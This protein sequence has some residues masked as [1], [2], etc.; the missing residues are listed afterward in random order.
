MCFSISGFSVS[1]QGQQERGEEGGGDGGRAGSDRWTDDNDSYLFLRAFLHFDPWQMTD[2]S[3]GRQMLSSTGDTGDEWQ[4][5]RRDACGGRRSTWRIQAGRES[6]L[7]ESE[8]MWARKQEKFQE[9]DG[10]KNGWGY[11][12]RNT[13]VRTQTDI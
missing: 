11:T 5:G 1:N 7:S 10:S 8:V 2:L 3:T 13:C 6:D 4:S 12:R 9:I